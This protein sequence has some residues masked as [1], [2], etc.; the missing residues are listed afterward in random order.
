MSGDNMGILDKILGK[1]QEETE[2]LEDVLNLSMEEG[3]AVNPPAKMYVKKVDLR[4]EGDVDYVLKQIQE[5]NVVIISIKP[6]KAQP[7]RLNRFISKIKTNVLK[8]NGDLALLTNELIIV[9]PDGV[10]IV[11]SRRM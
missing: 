4:N 10:K 1:K 9:T 5:G 2:D 6:I 11:K 3:D 7:K 8:V